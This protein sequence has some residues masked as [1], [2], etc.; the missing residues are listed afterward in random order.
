[1]KPSSRKRKADLSCFPTWCRQFHPNLSAPRVFFGVDIVFKA[2]DA[3]ENV[4][5]V[6]NSDIHYYYLD[7]GM[8]RSMSM[9]DHYKHKVNSKNLAYA[10]VSAKS[11]QPEVV[12]F[13]AKF[14]FRTLRGLK[15]VT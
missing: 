13:K 2:H 1:M 6:D 15:W 14:G 7:I 5:V 12:R 4:E 9:E 3:R 11:D 8:S 10:V